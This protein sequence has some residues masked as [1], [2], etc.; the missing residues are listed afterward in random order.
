M[1]AEL[2]NPALLERHAAGLGL[3]TYDSNGDMQGIFKDVFVGRWSTFEKFVF[4][5]YSDELVEK[6]V[7]KVVVKPS[8]SESEQDDAMMSEAAAN[9]RILHSRGIA[10]VEKAEAGRRAGG[11]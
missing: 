6:L 7:K 5:C 4:A 10:M 9:I 3:L 8:M 1:A 2:Q 11:L